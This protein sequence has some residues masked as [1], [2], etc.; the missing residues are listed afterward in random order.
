[1][2][3]VLIIILAIT[4]ATNSFGQSEEQQE[5]TRE[6]EMLYKIEMTSWKGT[7]ILL[8]KFSKLLPKVEGYFSYLEKGSA[9]CIFYSQGDHPKILASIAFP[10]DNTSTG[11]VNRHRHEF[12][13]LETG[14]WKIG[15]KTMEELHTDS[16][17]KFYPDTTPNIVPVID[18]KGKRAYVLTGTK[19]Y[20][21]V[22]LGN[23]YLLTF[24]D[25]FNLME[26]KVLHRNLITLEYG[27]SDNGKI[28][29]SMHTHLPET[30]D[31]ITATDICSFMLYQ[32]QA[33]WREHY[34][35]SNK[36]VSIWNCLTNQLTVTSREV[37][38]KIIDECGD[39]N[40]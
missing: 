15:Q 1:M 11:I 26:K 30:G 14:L 5:I 2:K 19:K 27:N 6:G 7:D 28:L 35:I 34:V 17:F 10:D 4:T 39:S 33:K 38:E 31:L 9:Q 37:W 16:L 21:I 20:G 40:R 32:K 12:S 36:S 25:E 24:D 8:A 29:A 13:T 18:E 3:K 23:D 22:I